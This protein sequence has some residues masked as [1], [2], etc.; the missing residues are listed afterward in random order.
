MVSVLCFG[1]FDGLHPGHEAFFRQARELGDRLLVVLSRDVTVLEV[2]GQLPGLG[3]E[4]RLRQVKNHP[5]V[6]EAHL[7]H[8]GDKYKIVE[9]LKPD[10]ILL[11]YDQQAFTDSLEKE[12]QQR[13]LWIEI[14][15]AQPHR[16][17]VFK[18]SLRRPVFTPV[19]IRE[20]EEGIPL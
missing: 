13:G 3:E 4:E 11:G 1:T 2:K 12:L 16:P 17:E 20:D 5:L 9:E 19:E 8:L 7:G 18:T 14:R 10:L 15:R 6:D